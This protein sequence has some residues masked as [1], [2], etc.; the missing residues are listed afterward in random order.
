MR[1]WLASFWQVQGLWSLYDFSLL[2]TKP[3][4]GPMAA[5][6]NLLH[7]RPL[8]LSPRV[9]PRAQKMDMLCD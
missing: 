5:P 2:H 8:E 3:G 1:I 7:A 6:A 9:Q 4:L